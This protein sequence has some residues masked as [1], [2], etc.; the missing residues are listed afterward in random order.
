MEELIRCVIPRGSQHSASPHYRYLPELIATVTPAS[1]SPARRL[2]DSEV[3]HPEYVIWTW[4]LVEVK[5]VFTNVSRLRHE[6]TFTKV[7]FLK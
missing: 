7:I 6:F 1:C 2:A 5:P 3:S 4:P